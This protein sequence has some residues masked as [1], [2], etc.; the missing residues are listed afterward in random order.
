MVGKDVLTG[1]QNLLRQALWY[2]F[3][4]Y[5]ALGKGAFKNEDRIVQLH[6]CEKPRRD[7]QLETT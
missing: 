7:M 1:E 6:V 3:D 2:N 4:Y 5:H